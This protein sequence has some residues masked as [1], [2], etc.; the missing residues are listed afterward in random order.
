MEMVPSEEAQAS[1]KPSS[2]GAKL[3]LLMEAL[4]RVEG[5]R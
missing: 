1:I 3:M 5:V 4:C 2:Y